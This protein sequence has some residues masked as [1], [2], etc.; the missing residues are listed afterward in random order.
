MRYAI[1]AVSMI[2][3][4]RPAFAQQ[5]PSAADQDEKKQ[6]EKKKADEKKE[7]EPEEMPTY[8]ET[9][10]VT[11]SRTEES[12]LDV[13]VSTTVIGSE[14]IETAAGDNYADLLR[15]VPGL[16]VVQNSARDINFVS[17][18]AASTLATS[19]LA[20]VDGR[21][22]YQDFFGFVMWDVL[23]VNFDEIDQIE[24][25]RGP[26][27]AVWGANA[28]AGVINVRTKSPRET[29]GGMFKVG[30]GE[31]GTR[32]ASVRFAQAFDKASYRIAASWFEQDAWERST[33]LP[34][35]TPLPPE[36]AFANEG[37]EQ[38]KIDLRVDW[39]ASDERRFSY[40]LGYSGTSG[41]MHTG[42]GPFTIDTDTRVAYGEFSYEGP[43][44]EA[45]AYI[46]SIDGD[47]TNLLNALPFAFQNNTYVADATWRHPFGDKN[48]LLIGGNGRLNKFDLSLAPNEDTREELGFFVEDQI[49]FG[50]KGI[51]SLGA[52]VDWF[53]TVGTTF[54]PRV[55]YVWKPV[56]HHSIRFAYNQAYRAPSL[57]NNYLDTVV[58]NAI[59]LIPNTPPFVFFTAAEGNPDL[60]EETVQAYEI[61]YT[62]ETGRHTFTAAV[63]RNDSKD[64]IDFYPAAYYSAADP[65]AG[66]PLPPAFVP[67]DTLPKLF[68]YRN[69]GKVQAQGI[70]LSWN[71]GW[72]RAFSTV[73]TY[74]YQDRN[75]ATDNDPTQPLVLNQPPHN[76]ATFGL[77]YN[78]EHWKGSFSASYVD[79]AFWS[80]VLDQR[81]WGWT[82]E[83]TTLSG[84]VGWENEHFGVK[85]SGTNLTDEEIQQHVFG[86]ILRRKVMLEV[87]F[88]W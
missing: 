27:S 67:P 24:V 7:A 25:L 21:S 5:P 81:Y 14:Q 15:G 83:Y 41:I 80:D 79:E 40:K 73:L 74:S 57:I 34:D 12:L 69:V 46:N 71:A 61:G 75:R 59:Q 76:Q 64:L 30:A 68:S 4:F 2:L 16:N 44:L 87:K 54:S 18:G 60:N 47:A 56:E 6:E 78:G 26:G 72:T 19:Q 48:L 17:R 45:K 42:I 37:S 50:E 9:V 39:D 10:V 22:I 33:T 29:P 23:P 35:G 88:M 58:P 20:L 63:Y 38:P 84:G 53:D 51:L 85:L 66:W 31:I 70:E 49:M 55:S 52:R 32:S 13:P 62:A 28:L 43:E 3:A 8:A 1:A 36:A 77:S 86:D 65:P 11:A 82:D